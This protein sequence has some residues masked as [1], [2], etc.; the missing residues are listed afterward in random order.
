MKP[1]KV[2]GHEL[3]L[4]QVTTRAVKAGEVLFEERPLLVGPSPLTAPQCLH[5]GQ[6]IVGNFVCGECG[7]PMCSEACS[8]SAGHRH[9]ECGVIKELRQARSV[10]AAKSAC[11]TV[12]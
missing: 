6:K 2:P 9:R 3:E 8:A 1:V 5:C 11:S 12:C 10:L 7:M 4:L